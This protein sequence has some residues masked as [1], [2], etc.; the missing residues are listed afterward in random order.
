MSTSISPATPINPIVETYSRLARE[1]DDDANFRSCWG[2]ASER[3]LSAIRLRDD[4]DVIVDMG[5]GTGRA[6]HA[7]ASA[8]PPRMRFIGIDPAGNMCSI[9]AQKAAQQKSVQIRQGCFETMPLETASVDYLYS[10]LAFHWVTD[11]AAS[12]AEIARVLKPNGEMDLFF[13]GRDNG[14]EFIQK[15]SAIFLKY[16]GPALLLDSARL[17]KQLTREAAQ[18]LFS[19]AFEPPRLS[20][21][22]S[23]TTYYDT[24]EG[25]WSWWVRVEGH[26][27]K[28]P[29]E[30]KAQ[31]DR[32]VR[33]AL[34]SLAEPRGIPYTIHELHVKLRRPDA[35]R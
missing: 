12:V 33:L 28:I 32:D 20:V 9:A 34:Q 16:M 22:E 31:C 1:Y 24:L 18:D 30:K 4:Y 2:R 10:I 6:I 17:R 7:L 29:A 19:T 13:I 5:C 25:H 27:V 26:F 15:T 23:L 35:L 8:A 11:L 3:A 14:R 21:E